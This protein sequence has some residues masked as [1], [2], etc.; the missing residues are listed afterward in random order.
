MQLKKAKEN[1]IKEIFLE[2]VSMMKKV[3]E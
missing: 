2:T 3:K 1:D